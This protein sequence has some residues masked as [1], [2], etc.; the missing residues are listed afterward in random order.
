MTP[1]A[2]FNCY[3]NVTDDLS[4]GLSLF[5]AELKRAKELLQ[6][7]RG[8]PTNR[9]SFTLID[10]LFSGTSPQ[11]GACSLASCG[12]IGSIQQ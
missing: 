7:I 11:E 10:E 1:F 9:F 2:A 12:T 5:K 4:A 6:T 3:L 8:L